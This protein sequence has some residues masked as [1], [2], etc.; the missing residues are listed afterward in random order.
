MLADP[1][2]HDRPRLRTERTLIRD[3]WGDWGRLAAELVRSPWH[4]VLAHLADRPRDFRGAIARVRRDVRSIYLA[5]LQ[6]HLWNLMLADLLAE[7]LPADRLVAIP[8]AGHPLPFPRSLENGEREMLRLTELPLPSARSRDRLQP[9]QAIVEKAA[10]A[11]GL[12]LSQ[13]RVKYPRDSFFS[14]GSRSAMFFPE[15]VSHGV[16]ADELY[17]GRKKM[18]FQCELPRGAYATIL[19]RRIAAAASRD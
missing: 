19:T 2:A 6:S 9:W 13:L 17:D 4:A 12:T 3:H 16:E 7:R 11:V 15:R 18:V 5:A 10:G 8:V 1:N 14:K